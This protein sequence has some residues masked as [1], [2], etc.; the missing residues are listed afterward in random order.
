MGYLYEINCELAKIY[1][2]A[3][4]KNNPYLEAE[5]FINDIMKEETDD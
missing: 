4:I 3:S 5:E 2:K 1:I